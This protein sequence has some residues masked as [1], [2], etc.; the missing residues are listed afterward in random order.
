GLLSVAFPPNYA[1]SGF[2]YVFYTA[3]APFGSLVIA[4]YQVTGDPNVAGPTELQR[5]VVIPHP[6]GNHNGG[7][8]QF[9]PDGCLYAGT[10][11]G[12]GSGDPNRNAQNLGSLLGKLL[13]LDPATGNACANVRS[14]PFVATPGAE[15][16]WALGLRNPFRFSFDRQTGDLYIGDV[17]QST[18]EEVDVQPANDP[19]GR[20]YC[21]SALEG[22]LPFN[23]DQ[24]CS[25]GIATPPIVQY[26]HT[27]GRCAVIGG[28]AYRGS[29]GTLAPGVYVFG[30]LCSGEVFFR[31][32]GFT[33][34]LF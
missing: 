32:G 9:G 16:I 18:R 30:D 15:P 13:R 23:G 21:W 24:N 26:G 29:A 25:T 20:N 1:S 4:R 19:G 14:N 12:G 17:G 34:L 33:G 5:L 28:Y 8:L 7:Q 2:F 11:D 6:N 22:T 3:A 27:G 31:Q 10:G